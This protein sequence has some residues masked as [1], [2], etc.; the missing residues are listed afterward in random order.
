M[1]KR[2]T[3]IV[4]FLLATYLGVN[5]QAAGTPPSYYPIIEN[6]L[7]KSDEDLT[8]EKKNVSAKY[9]LSRA[10][11]MMEAYNV[12]LQ[13]L[14]KGTAQL[15]I[16]ILFGEPKN[17]TTETKDDK[18][19]ETCVYDRVNVT[20]LNGVLDSYEETKPLYNNPLPVAKEALDKAMELD[21]DKKLTK[22]ILDGYEK[23]A[24]LFERQAIEA[25]LKEDFNGSYNNFKESVAIGQMPIMEGV[26]IDTSTI[27]NTGMAASRAD[28]T[29]ESIKYYELALSY[30][31]PE[32]K[33]Y[34]YLYH[35][36]LAK[37]DT[38]KGVNFLTEGFDKY[39]DNQEIV[40]ELINYY[41][42][43]GKGDQ[44]LEYIKIAQGKDPNNVSLIFAEATL[45][46]KQG[47]LK[48]AIEKYL[49]CIEIDPTYFNAYYN[50]GV[51]Y[52]NHAQKLYDDANNA[53]N[54][55]YKAIVE[56]GDNELKNAI[57]MMKKCYELRPEDRTSLETL[58]SIYYRLKMMDDYKEVKEILDNL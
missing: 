56:K 39:P 41:L 44:A 53:P 50:L 49:K 28:L 51:A 20:F 45:Y 52:Y 3:L 22:K 35:L 43:A 24:D 58:K 21:V 6:K 13:Y 7:K 46:D 4:L 25:F 8:N 14:L 29:D 17:K 18:L 33:L 34:G 48:L 38:T 47:K 12:N 37:S 55:E 2:T 19:Y 36:Y 5:A 11:I 54:N 30:H 57:P 32:P 26:A 23:L 31:Y 10:D 16:T 9:W 15:Q 40:V 42:L 27:V 1:N